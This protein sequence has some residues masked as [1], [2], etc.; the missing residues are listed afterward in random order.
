MAYDLHGSW[1]NKIGHHS[2]Y[3]PHKDDPV[4]D[5]ASTNYAVQYWTGKGLP[6]EKLV[7]GMPAYGRC[8]STNVDEPRVGDPATGASPAGTHT[9]EAGFLSY[10]EICDNI[11]NKNWKV[12]YSSTMQAPFAYGDGQWC[13]S[14]FKIIQNYQLHSM[15][16]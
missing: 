7:F 11:E 16:S 12:R 13:G 2:Q 15:Y 5:I 6:A 1:E 4:G 10:Y 14:G 8:F 3:R 9:K